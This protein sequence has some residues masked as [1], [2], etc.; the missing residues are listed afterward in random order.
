MDGA[1]DAR[2][3]PFESQQGSAEFITPETITTPYVRADIPRDRLTVYA[4]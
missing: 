1:C 4:A 3:P 2:H